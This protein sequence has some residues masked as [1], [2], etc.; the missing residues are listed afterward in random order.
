KEAKVNYAGTTLAVVWSDPDQ[1]Y[2][3][4]AA[5]ESVFKERDLDATIL[6]GP[7]RDK[8]LH[9]Y[10][11]GRWY[12]TGEVDRL[13]ET[14]A[15][16]IATRLINR[17]HLDLDPDKLTAL[18]RDLSSGI[19]AIL[20][21]EKGEECARDPFEELSKVA[22]KY[23]DERQMARLEKAAQRGARALPGE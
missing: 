19:A 2:S 18:N 5:V 11:S 23:L 10:G 9:E 3:G 16:V 7:A 15:H 4:A 13:S 8:A 14:E 1:A 12:G 20:T 22:S 17:A 21:R 6:R